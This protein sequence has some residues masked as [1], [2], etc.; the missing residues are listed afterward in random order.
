MKKFKTTVVKQESRYRSGAC[1]VAMGALL[2]AGC[3]SFAPATPEQMV[4]Q[5]ATA[6]WQAR[7]TGQVDKAYAL[8]TPSYRQLRTEA[9]FKTQFGSSL[10]IESAEIKKIDCEIDKCNVQ[11]RMS[12]KPQLPGVKLGAINTYVNELWLLEAGEWWRYQEM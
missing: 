1:A 4:Q 5:R 9:Q 11:L 10:S 6:Y 12:V 7:I 8:S 3:A 2:L